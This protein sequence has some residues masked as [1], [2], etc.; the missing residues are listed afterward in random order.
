MTAED[1]QDILISNITAE[2]QQD[3]LISNR[4][5]GDK[6]VQ[7]SDFCGR[8]SADAPTRDRLGFMWKFRLFLGQ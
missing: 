2:D 5:A 3:I 6:Q 7:R 1:Q 4:T 8:I